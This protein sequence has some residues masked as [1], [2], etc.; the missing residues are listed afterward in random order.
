MLINFLRKSA[1]SAAVLLAAALM[2]SGPVSS[3]DPVLFSG[4]VYQVNDVAVVHGAGFSAGASVSIRIVSP[5]GET[6][7]LSATADAEGN[8][9]V[10]VV[11]NDV[12]QFFAVL[13]DGENEPVTSISMTVS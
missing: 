9:A 6:T 12:G 4:S 2:L 3:A 8:I 7:D 1:K 5:S 10:Q 13:L 11:L